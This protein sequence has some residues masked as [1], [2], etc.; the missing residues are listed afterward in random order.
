MAL[1]LIASPAIEPVSLDE[2]KSHLRVDGTDDD[3][4]IT[5]LIAAA[6]RWCEKFQRRAYITQTWELWLDSWPEK[7]YIIIPRPPLQD[8]SSVKYYGTDDSE[9]T[10]DQANY[11]VD[12]KSEPGRVVLGY[13]KNWPSVTLRPANGVVVT[14]TAGYGDNAEKVPE[15]VKQ[16]MKLLIGHWY[17]HREAVLAGIISK[18]IEFAVRSLLWPDRVVLV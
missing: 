17:E 3:N 1:K 9:Y 10:F 2:A 11:F 6:R 18:E 8:V 7:N 13:K 16:A 5:S 4:L 15:E 14:F 12:T